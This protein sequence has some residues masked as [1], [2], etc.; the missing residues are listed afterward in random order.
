MFYYQQGDVLVKKASDFGKDITIEQLEN[1]ANFKKQE[2]LLVHTG[3]H[4]HHALASN[5]TIYTSEKEMFIVVNEG[6]SDLT[7]AEHAT[8]HVEPGIYFK[9]IVQEFDH[10]ANEA[11]NVLD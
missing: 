5:A 9:D 7:H 11:R 2:N 10:D 1:T 8:I 4:H 3:L 6:G